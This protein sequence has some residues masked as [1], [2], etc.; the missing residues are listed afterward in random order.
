[1]LQKMSLL[2]THT[3]F[4]GFPAVW[5]DI[6]THSTNGDTPRFLQFTE[7]VVA[8]C[9]IKSG[10]PGL[11]LTKCSIGEGFLGTCIVPDAQ[12]AR[13]G[14]D[15][16]ARRRFRRR[17]TGRSW[18]RS[19]SRRAGFRGQGHRSLAA[20]GE[21]C[22]A[23]SSTGPRCRLPCRCASD[24]FSSTISRTK[25]Q[26][27]TARNVDGPGGTAM[28]VVIR[29]Y[30]A[31]AKAEE[32]AQRVGEGLVPI[33]QALEGFR[34]YYAFVGEDG[35]PVSVSIVAN[36]S[37][38]LAANDR[39]RAMGDRRHGRADPGPAGGRHGHDAGRCRDR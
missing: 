3:L 14:T 9:G 26:P 10:F 1:M 4:F 24:S 38:A 30:A 27:F 36:R 31:G 33:L 35:R 11:V 29:R 18:L 19:R 25:A 39:A 21:H 28:Y 37:A 22:R 6:Q 32:V 7:I 17:H 16:D 23:R 12:P 13:R 34:A 2:S 5:A 8:G 15:Q 20:D